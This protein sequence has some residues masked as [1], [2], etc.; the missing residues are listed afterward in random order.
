MNQPCL[1]PVP[2]PLSHGLHLGALGH[3]GRDLLASPACSLALTIVLLLQP[4][5]DPEDPAF[6]DFYVFYLL[7]VVRNLLPWSQPAYS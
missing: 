6:W 5:Q 7:R 1:I 3:I 4:A 2:T